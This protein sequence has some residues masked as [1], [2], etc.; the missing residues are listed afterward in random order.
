MSSIKRKCQVVLL[1]TTANTAKFGTF[2]TIYN[3]IDKHKTILRQ[4]KESLPV[5][6][7]MAA[8]YKAVNL[9]VLSDEEIKESD[10]FI[11]LTNNT[12]NQA[13]N[14]IYVSTCKKIIATTDS[15]LKIIIPRHNDFDS[16]Y[17]LPQPSPQFIAKYIEEHNK[18]N[19]ITEV[20]VEY[21][22]Y[23]KDISCGKNS[24]YLTN[25]CENLGYKLK[26][27]S[28]NC[29]TITKVKDNFTRK[30]TLKF[31]IDFANHCMKQV[32]LEINCVGEMLNFEQNL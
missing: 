10:W 13:I 12:I 30:E 14:W 26:T 22:E 2:D 32:N 6:D 7:I 19:I 8:A 21:E 9:Y 15:S 29:I 18:G 3:G 5:N 25:K 4:F 1:H 16:E 17:L 27:D 23:C 20:M 28:N 31:A 11:N 24:C